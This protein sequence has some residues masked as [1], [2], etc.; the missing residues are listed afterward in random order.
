MYIIEPCCASRQLMQIRDA[1]GRNG[2]V[3]FE[4][5]GDMS[6]TELLPAIMTRYSETELLIAAPAMPD[7]AAEVITRWMNQKWSRSDGRGKLNA[8]RRL[9]I[10]AD[11][12]E[13][14]SPVASGW[15]KGSPFGERLT[16]VDRQQ[17]D[18][19]ILLPDFAVT[20][21]VNMR[22]GRHFVAT[23]T[24]HKDSVDSLWRKYRPDDKPAEEP[25]GTEAGT[26]TPAEEPANKPAEEPANKPA[27]EPAGTVAEESPKKGKPGHEA[28]R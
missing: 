9:T 3:L 10:I 15:L 16:L 5:Y 19:A 14:V 2:S 17:A 12:S 24:V 26:A 8:I 11:L 22:Y 21:P 23:A 28:G 20:G 4:G 18:T 1:M 7:Q 6:L 25:A 13:E 27:E